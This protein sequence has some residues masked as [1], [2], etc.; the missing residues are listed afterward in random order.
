MFMKLALVVFLAIFQCEGSFRLDIL[1]ALRDPCSRIM[2][3]QSGTI[4]RGMGRCGDLCNPD[5]IC[6][7][8]LLYNCYCQE[9]YCRKDGK[10]VMESEKA[11]Q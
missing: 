6:G 10:C 11:T 5:M 4:C 1:N 7:H 3:H 8:I 9:G 2:C